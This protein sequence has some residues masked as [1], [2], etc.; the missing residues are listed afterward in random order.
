MIKNIEGIVLSETSYRE[1]SKI[2]KV[3]TKEGIVSFLAKGAKSLKSSLRNSTTKLT[4]GLFSSNLKNDGL[5]TLI[6]VDTLDNFKNIKKDIKKISYASFILD[7]A[8]QVGKNNFE[9]DIFTFALA[10]LKKIDEGFDSLVITNILELKYLFYLGVM[11][12][13][14]ACSIC[15]SR[16][17]IC[18]LSSDKGGYVCK[19]CLDKEPKVSE[20]A[21][22]LVRMYYYVDIS[23]ITKLEVSDSVKEEINTF[24]DL[25]YDRYTGLYLKTKDFLKNLNKIQI[26]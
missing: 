19:N 5:S 12:N 2:I 1:T 25:Y 9:E 10:S 18:T 11:P 22:K 20:K 6:S 4:Y 15:G 17:N 8:Y 23:K 14:D 3:L 7:L 21:I 13:L 16:E 24:L 26:K